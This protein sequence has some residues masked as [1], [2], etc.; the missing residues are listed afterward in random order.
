MTTLD[1]NT[2]TNETFETIIRNLIGT[3]CRIEFSNYTEEHENIALN[4][5]LTVFTGDTL[6][7]LDEEDESNNYF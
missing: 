5:G 7:V 3:D 4:L 2:Q 6:T 1:L